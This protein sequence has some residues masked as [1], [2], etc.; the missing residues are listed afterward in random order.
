MLDIVWNFLNKSHVIRITPGLCSSVLIIEPEPGA[1]Y[2][3]GHSI[4]EIAQRYHIHPDAIIKLGSNEN[5]LGPAPAAVRAIIEDAGNVS[6]YPDSDASDLCDAISGYTGYP[7]ENIVAGAGM[8]GVID[9]LMRMLM[10]GEAII[11]IP[12]FSYYE[13]AV[14]LHHS[15]PIFVSRDQNFGIDPQEILSRVTD[16]TRIVILCS[17][18]NPSGNLIPESDL[19]SII[20]GCGAIVF[21]DEAYVEFSDRN[22]MHLVR[23]YDNLIIGRTLSKAFGLAGLRVGYAIMPEQMR[24][25]Y[26]EYATPFSVSSLGIAAGIAAFGDEKHLKKSIELVQNGRRK[27]ME[28]PFDVYPSDANF[29]LV[30]VSPHRSGDVCDFLARDGIIVRDCSSFR[31]A[32]S[33][34][35]RV[36]V[37]MPEQNERVV[38]TFGE[39]AAETQRS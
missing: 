19:R 5:P 2:V 9:T 37:G 8:D 22:M 14:R 7:N 3:P 6:I 17:P 4:A 32:G 1:S 33:S 15:T 38:Q 12:T 34:L 27:L 21:L 11:P 26:M 36:S 23:E 10:S 20:E 24:D 13:I 25:R 16:D 18:N 29:V 31:G 28:I 30:D 35:V 39:F